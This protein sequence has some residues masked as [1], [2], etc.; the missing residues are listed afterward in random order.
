MYMIAVQA[1]CVCVCV[2]G[3][4]AVYVVSNVLDTKGVHPSHGGEYYFKFGV[5]NP[6]FW[7]IVKC[8]LISFSG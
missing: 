2:W 4:G 8:K 5:L 1:V 3:G 6:G 7:C